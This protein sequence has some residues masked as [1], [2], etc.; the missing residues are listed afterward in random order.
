MSTMVLIVWSKLLFRQSKWVIDFEWWKTMTQVGG[1]CSVRSKGYIKSQI[2]LRSMELDKFHSRIVRSFVERRL[3]LCLHCT[4]GDLQHKRQTR[5]DRDRDWS[6]TKQVQEHHDNRATGVYSKV[7]VFSIESGQKAQKTSTS[8]RRQGYVHE[9]EWRMKGRCQSGHI[10][11]PQRRPWWPIWKLMVLIF[12]METWYSNFAVTTRNVHVSG[13]HVTGSHGKDYVR[14]DNVITN[15]MGVNI[16]HPTN[17]NRSN[18]GV[19][20]SKEKVQEC[21][22][23]ICNSEIF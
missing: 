19:M 10:Q 12:F 2:S 23:V 11:V 17:T 16:G 13:G 4:R 18:D 14:G 6:T 1:S 20:W 3:S 8:C 21:L 15:K 22:G 9:K 5:C 7:Q